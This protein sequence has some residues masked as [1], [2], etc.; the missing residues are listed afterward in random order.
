MVNSGWV[1]LLSSSYVDYYGPFVI[2]R[3]I[4]SVDYILFSRRE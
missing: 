4:I 1:M 2:F 3:I